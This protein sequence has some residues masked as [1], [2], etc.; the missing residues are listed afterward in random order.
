MSR[1][2]SY[3]SRN[4]NNIV[5]QINLYANLKNVPDEFFLLICFFSSLFGHQ[6]I[7][8]TDKQTIHTEKKNQT[9]K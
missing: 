3:I 8:Q 9:Q 4:E 2:H 7:N 5:K 6:S 1:D